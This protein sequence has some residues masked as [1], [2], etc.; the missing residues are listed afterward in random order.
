M[1]GNS[2]VANVD[3]LLQIAE[4]EQVFSQMSLDAI[5]VGD[6]GTQIGAG[7][8]A[9][10]DGLKAAEAIL[11]ASIIDNSGS[12]AG[13][14]NGSESVCAGQNLYIDAFE[15]SRNEAGILMGT[16]L[17]N[18]DDPVHPFVAVPDA[19]RLENGVNYHAS[20]ITP[21]YRRSCAVMATLGL[22]MQVEYLEAGCACRGILLIVTDG[23][24]E[25]Y[26]GS[27]K[28]ITAAHCRA[29][30]EDLGEILIV[31]FMG[32]EGNDQVDFR[33]IALEMG[34]Q[35]Q[36]IITPKADPHSIRQAFE[37]ASKSAVSA[38]ASVDSF[39]KTAI[40]GFTS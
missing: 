38:S 30:I 25:D 10:P 33:Q 26:G 23:R 21:L 15:A 17:V 14:P 29:M 40:N 8:G 24:D 16:W 37:F 22:K 20:G 4:E 5:K 27:G 9:T 1:G 31:Q 34:V 28:N 3:S 36:H 6:L 32:I 35:D 19:V 18:E 11:V 7:L 13:I 39:S 2:K 12:I